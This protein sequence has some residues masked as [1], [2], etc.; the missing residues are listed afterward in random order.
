M[1][2]HR[3]SFAVESWPFKTPYRFAGHVWTSLDLFVARVSDGTHEGVGEGAGVYYHRE[4]VAEMPA[5]AERLR[6]A[7]ENGLGRDELQRRIPPSGV[8]NAIDCALWDLEAKRS[9]MPAWQRAGLSELKSLTCVQTL[10]IAD[11]EDMASAALAIPSARALKLKLA[12][13]GLDAARVRAVRAVRPRAWIGVDANQSLTLRTLDELVPALEEARVDMLEQPLPVGKDDVL[14][15]RSWPI[16]LA[17]DESVQ[18]TADIAALAGRYQIVNI[19]LD[20]SGG[21]TEA[22]RMAKEA[23]SLGLKIMV[24]NMLGTSRA[25]APGM[26]V[27]QFCEVVD[28]DG[29]LL[30]G[31]DVPDGLD[32]SGGFVR[33]GAC[34]WGQP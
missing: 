20:K 7:L 31:S 6:D 2:A 4:S 8:R 14:D 13:D 1:M 9:G 5:R 11:P 18:T 23:R 12:G 26:V 33:P 24:G 3:W 27:G 34:R 19:K 21:L 30:V 29:P 22:L 15:G 16:P 17:A 32:Y 25:M 28:L 10:S